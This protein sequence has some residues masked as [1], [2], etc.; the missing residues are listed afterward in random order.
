M[1]KPTLKRLGL[2]LLQQI[3]ALLILIAI[4]AV[5][6][7]SYV[8]VTSM[9]GTATYQVEPFQSE[10]NFEESELFDNI[11]KTAVGDITKLVVI[12]EQLETEGEFD[13][14]KNIDI[15][16]F[17]SRKGNGNGCPVTAVYELDDLIKW[18]IYGVEYVTRT[19]SMSDFIYYFEDV[20][21]PENFAL[22]EYGELYFK[23][24]EAND[25]YGMDETEQEDAIE[26]SVMEQPVIK[27]MQS[28][29][30]EELVEMIFSYIVAEIPE[31]IRVS[32]E[33]DGILN[34]NLEM[35]TCRYATVDGAQQLFYY[36]DNWVD[37]MKLQSNLAETIES[38]ANNY[39]QYQNTN[40]IYQEGNNNIKYMVRMMTEDG[41]RTYTNVSEIAEY[42]DSQI[43]EYFAEYKKYF[44]YFPDSLEFTGNTNLT[45][46]EMSD[47]MREYDYAYPETTHIWIAVDTSYGVIGDDM[48]NAHEVFDKIVPH[49][50]MIVAA[51]IVL[52]VIWLALCIYLTV[53]A[54]IGFDEEGEQVRYL[55]PLDHVWLEL[56]VLSGIVL[57]YAGYAGFVKLLGIADL[58]YQN[59]SEIMGFNISR[60][61]KYGSFGGYGFVMS[62]S[63]CVIWYSLVRRLKFGGAWRDSFV[64]WFICSIGKGIH[65]VLSHSNTAISTLLPY[66]IFLLV[67]LL[68]VFL[69]YILR[70]QAV[71]IIVIMIGLVVFDGL[72]GLFLF[73]NNA[74]RL[75][76]IAGIKRIREGEVEYKLDLDSLHGS[77]R[78]MADAVN[79]IGEG[80]RK[81]V[82]TSMK[83]E[84]M[85][86][87]LITNVSH[88][89]KT[90]LTSIINYVDLLKRLKIQDEPAKD[91]I[92][93]LDTKSQ[94]L[95]QLADDLVEASKLSSGNIELDREQINLT[96]LL[97]Q[98]VG[99]FA[100]RMEEKGLKLIFEGNARQAF[101]YAD[102]RR[103]WRVVE[104]L[105]NNI[106]KY[107]L[108]NTRV[109]LDLYLEEHEYG[110]SIEV[111][112][113]NISERQMNIR[114][115][116]LTER[117]IRGDASRATE[118]SGLGLYIAKNL[119]E[120]QGGD[121]EI[122]LD[123]DLFKVVIRFPEYI[124][125]EEPC[126]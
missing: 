70:F 126:E 84:Q 92:H 89:I 90:P 125:P 98:A 108:E 66:N 104:N 87:D 77:N 47:F 105:F 86:T 103:M 71:A 54:G 24:F 53:S 63:F 16:E 57:I 28:Y 18:G 35:L 72:V 42:E 49:A 40:E 113:K 117:F 76:I 29:S 55:N 85:K 60:L 65:F 22:D 119:I 111:S 122:Q 94:R 83:D 68:G 1:R 102:S 61:Y 14:S 91:Y 30:A 81:A 118:G 21:V 17:A 20:C 12:R 124:I 99:E 3:T 39:Q 38:L 82:R 11:F 110:R 101:I 5:L 25:V 106:Y 109:Y 58:V 93:V 73:R 96:E 114:A 36:A 15:T 75:D 80:I 2:G 26:F 8:S 74:E 32:R 95:K 27:V 50:D 121:F 107:A 7:N 45:Q 69:I 43:T 31:N 123:G 67:N 100:E 9:N 116:D 37:Y 10:K 64:Y 120:A 23:G 46:K 59:H 56:L 115:D 34:V 51:I 88:D 41:V 6:F 48:Y 13:G 112:V 97:N 78:E 4:A 33:D 79:N 44:V 19:M 52:A 62:M